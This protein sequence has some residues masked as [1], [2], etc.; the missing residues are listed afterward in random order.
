M[1]H[2]KI[3]PPSPTAADYD[4]APASEVAQIDEGQNPFKLFAKWLELATKSELNDPNAVALASCDENAMPDVR[5]VLLK[6]FDENGFVFFT[7]FQSAKGVQLLSNQKAAMCF[8]WKSLRRQVRI[9]GEIEIVSEQEAD[10]YFASRARQA[11]IGAWASEQSRPMKSL[12]ELVGRVAQFGL[13]FGV[14]KV[15]RPPHW[16]GFRLIPQNIE[17][18]HDRAFRLHERVVFS[19]G[20][21]KSNWETKRLFP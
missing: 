4:N 21:E 17:F 10:N 1:T 16:S 7:N 9:R 20:S 14:G 19:R 6:E 11:Q 12:G 2:D 15:A 5:M 8:H 13:K 18:W 3:I